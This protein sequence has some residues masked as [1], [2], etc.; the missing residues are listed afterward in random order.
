M[1]A[2]FIVVLLNVLQVAKFVDDCV[3]R[4]LSICCSDIFVAPSASIL[5]VAPSQTANILLV[6]PSQTHFLLRELQKWKKR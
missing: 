6:A 4:V 3:R 5:R 1:L 2:M